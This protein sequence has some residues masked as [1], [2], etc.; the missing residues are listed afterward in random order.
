MPWDPQTF[1]HAHPAN[2]TEFSTVELNFSWFPQMRLTTIWCCKHFKTS[3]R[4]RLSRSQFMILSVIPGKHSRN[5]HTLLS[6]V[7]PNACTVFYLGYEMI[8]KRT[9]WLTERSALCVLL[10]KKSL[11][12]CTRPMWSCLRASSCSTLRKSETC[13]RWSCLLILIQ[14]H[15]CHV[16]VCSMSMPKYYCCNRPEK[17][18][19]KLIFELQQC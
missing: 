5:R 11:L 19:N 9:Q 7:D 10:G 1:L 12:Q 3:C 13:S 4:G 18:I 17:I 15:G 14:I 8:F 16:E 2:K 6:P